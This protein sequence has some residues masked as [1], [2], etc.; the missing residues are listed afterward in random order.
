MKHHLQGAIFGAILG[1]V[2]VIIL[3]F[4]VSVAAAVTIVDTEVVL[5]ELDRETI[6]CIE[7]VYYARTTRVTYRPDEPVFND[8]VYNEPATPSP[9][10]KPNAPTDLCDDELYAPPWCD[11]MLTPGV[12]NYF[13]AN[14]NS[15][16]YYEYTID[17]YTVESRVCKNCHVAT[18]ENSTAMSILIGALA[19]WLLYMWNNGGQC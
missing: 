15:D 12:V 6:G 9:Y 19:L 11:G 5:E 4:L 2:L 10:T 3:F 7:Y 8:V 13:P 16:L 18:P 17:Y 1:A 14:L